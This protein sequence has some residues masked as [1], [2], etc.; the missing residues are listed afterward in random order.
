MLPELIILFILFMT[1]FFFMTYEPIS[2]HIPIVPEPWEN[3]NKSYNKV[4]EDLD[5]WQNA[6]FG[7]DE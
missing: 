3:A 6:T 7:E 1:F 4:S 5:A 2:Q